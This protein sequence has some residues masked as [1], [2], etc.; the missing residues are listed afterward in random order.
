MDVI[1]NIMK[2]NNIKDRFLNKLNLLFHIKAL[3]HPHIWIRY[4]IPRWRTTNCNWGDD[5]NAN[6]CKIISG[7]EVI[8]YQY[9]WFNQQHYLCIGSII[10]WYSTENAIIWGSGLLKYTRGLRHPQRVLAVRGPLTRQCLLDNGIE[11]PEIYGDP[12]LLFPRYYNPSIDKKYYVGI[13]CHQSEIPILEKMIHSNKKIVFIDIKH[14]GKWTDFIDQILSCD[15]ILSSSLHGVIVADAY[16]IPNQWSQFTDYIS[17]NTGFK[18]RDYYLSVKKNITKPYLVEF[19]F[20]IKAVVN[21][22]K[23]NWT[24]PHFDAKQLLDACPFK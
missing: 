7:K 12:A 4:A 18:F 8:P 10:Q 16:N 6:L 2:Y 17:E 1:G 15:V 14:Y 3:L 23:N 9:S 20:D 13:I 22:V 21:N 11:C 19:P 5:V 24:E